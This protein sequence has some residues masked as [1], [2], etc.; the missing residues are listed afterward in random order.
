MSPELFLFQLLELVTVTVARGERVVLVSLGQCL[1]AI[2]SK[3][4][5][6]CYFS[7]PQAA[8]VQSYPPL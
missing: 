3:V 6:G 5:E 4:L 2:Q 1:L 8:S 7:A